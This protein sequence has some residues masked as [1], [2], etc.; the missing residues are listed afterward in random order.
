MV[1]SSSNC[2]FARAVRTLLG[3]LIDSRMESNFGQSI[4]KCS[5]VLRVL[6]RSQFG[7]KVSMP[8]K[9]CEM[10][11]CPV[12]S[13]E[14]VFCS[15]LDFRSI[16]LSVVFF[17]LRINRVELFDHSVS[18]A[19]EKV[20]F[21]QLFRSCDGT[22]LG[23][24]KGRDRPSLASRSASSFPLMLQ[25]PGIHS[26]VTLLGQLSCMYCSHGC[27][28]LGLLIPSIMLAESLMI[29]SGLSLWCPMASLI[30]FASAEKTV[31]CFGSLSA[32]ERFVPFMPYPV[33]L[34]ALDPSVYNL[35]WF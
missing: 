26:R 32:I 7:R 35:L 29:R 19:K 8:L 34:L 10:F 5:T 4:K 11:V 12:L 33:L 23:E 21:I 27:L 17:I 25:C 2:S 9:L 15:I 24:E 18:H 30:A 16:H 13:R 6:H 22:F 1:L 28:A 20:E 14:R 31:H 3:R